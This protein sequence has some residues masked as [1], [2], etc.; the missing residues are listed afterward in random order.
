MSSTPL[1]K[2][3]DYTGFKICIIWTPHTYQRLPQEGGKG[4][5]MWAIDPDLR[6]E[7]TCFS[8]LLEE[9]DIVCHRNC[10]TALGD[11]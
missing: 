8:T 9:H 3:E 10:K 4:S 7:C 6:Y 5:S 2:I 1:T 11:M